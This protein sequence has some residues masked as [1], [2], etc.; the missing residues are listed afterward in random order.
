MR[1]ALFLFVV[2]AV[3]CAGKADMAANSSL[4]PQQEFSQR[5]DFSSEF[6]N[7]NSRD[8]FS[9]FRSSLTEE[10]K[11]DWLGYQLA[12][13]E[14]L[15]GESSMAQR[16]ALNEARVLRLFTILPTELISEEQFLVTLEVYEYYASIQQSR[17]D[18]SVMYVNNPEQLSE[19]SQHLLL[20]QTASPL[21]LFIVAVRD[22]LNEEDAT[23][24]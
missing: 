22:V 11:L 15:F 10:Q 24:Y 17:G 3:G 9:K 7:I 23:V 19:S 16:C 12:R 5:V 20:S 1:C 8:S 13:C 21:A 18:Y 2:L 4:S 6:A 14:S